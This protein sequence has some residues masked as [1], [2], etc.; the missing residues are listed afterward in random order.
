[1]TGIGISELSSGSGGTLLDA[2]TVVFEVSR[3][4]TAIP[5]G[6][7]AMLGGWLSGLVQWEWTGAAETAALADG[8]VQCRRVWGRSRF[9]V[10]WMPYRGPGPRGE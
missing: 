7:T 3:T 2:A 10:G 9:R 1:M 4:A 8:I 6:E 5:I